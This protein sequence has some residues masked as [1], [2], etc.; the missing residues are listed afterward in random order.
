MPLTRHHT[1]GLLIATLI[2]VSCLGI[3]SRTP[4]FYGHHTK[5]LSHNGSAPALRAGPFGLPGSIP[6]GGVFG[7]LS[8]LLL[9]FGGNCGGALTFF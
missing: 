4:A 9:S 2:K 6:G 7:V 3:M 8:T 5:P 1:L